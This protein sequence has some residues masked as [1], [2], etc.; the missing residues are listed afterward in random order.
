MTT[1][2]KCTNCGL[3]NSYK[4]F[5]CQAC[6]EERPLA[7]P[8]MPLYDSKNNRITTDILV[9]GYIRKMINNN[10]PSEIINLCFLFWYIDV[11]D[12]WDKAISH[13]TAI[14]DGQCVRLDCDIYSTI[15]GSQVIESGQYQWLVKCETEIFAGGLGI[16]VIE[17]RDEL[18][19]ENQGG[20]YYGMNGDGCFLLNNGK[21]FYSKDIKDDITGYTPSFEDKGTIITLI[22]NTDKQSVCY[23][24]N[25]EDYGY[26]DAKCVKKEQ[27]Y[28]LA[29][30]LYG[31]DHEIA[32]L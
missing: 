11:C 20:Y 28:R 31:D 22:L 17:D 14:I 2:W 1:S 15:Y 3:S 32:L 9:S 30:T 16:G 25:D 12:S 26:V 8:S 4:N 27:K 18:L 13:Q 5:V 10:V 21:F 29:V 19:K 23:K 24:I 7:N 6:F